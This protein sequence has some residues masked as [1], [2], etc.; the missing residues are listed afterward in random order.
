MTKYAKERILA[1]AHSKTLK[2]NSVEML[3]VVWSRIVG[4]Q[5]PDQFLTRIRR[6]DY[7]VTVQMTK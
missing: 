2:D 6:S 7:K 1:H 5:Q 4:A 3:S